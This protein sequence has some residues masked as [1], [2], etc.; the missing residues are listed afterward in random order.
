VRLTPHAGRLTTYAGLALVGGVLTG[1][2]EIVVLGV[3]AS[4]VL[5]YGLLRRTPTLDVTIGVSQDRVHEGDDVQ[6]T[7]SLTASGIV[8]SATVGIVLPP[9]L[10]VVT[11]AP[12]A[13]VSVPEGMVRDVTLTVR[14]W[15]WGVYQVGPAIVT[16]YGPGRLT[17]TLVNADAVP[18]RV[19]PQPYPFAAS[20]EHP[21]TRVLSGSHAARA[22]GEGI[23]PVGVREY[24]PGDALRRV[25]W[26]VT[27]RRGVLHVTEARP[28]RNAEVVLFLDTF[29]DR[30]PAGATTLDVAVRS[31]VGIAEHYLRS[32]DRV[33]LV[34]FGG[35]MRWLT[36]DSGRLQR[37]RV[38]EHLIGT[39]VIQTYAAKDVSVLPARTLPP[40]AL[41]IALSPLLDTRA[42]TALVDIARRGFGLVVVDTSPR[43]LLPAAP[44]W[45]R[46][47]AQRIW[48]VERDALLHRLAEVGVPVVPW[49]GPGTLDVVL[50][51]VARLHARPRV[52]L[53]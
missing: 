19:L 29:V 8:D 13:T 37:Y 36:A 3:A 11:G 50:G 24:L 43:P 14:P 15:R 26:R 12:A 27:A 49:A 33:G 42:T 39:G 4:A 38:I 35:V 34:G 40:R 51:E 46:D 17:A 28:E 1:R 16:A 45:S 18:L 25:D 48:L 6:V 44:T 20:S 5:A 52:S 10:T 53:R 9:G 41:V 30:G 21:F 31:A 22:S 32:M 7:V 2:V 23:E 47:L